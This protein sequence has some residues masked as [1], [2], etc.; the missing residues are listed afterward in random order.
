MSGPKA[1]KESAEQRAAR[2]AEEER[3]RIAQARAD[4]EEAAAGRQFLTKRTRAV[5]RLFGARRALAGVG[6]ANPI[7]APG[8]GTASSGGLGGGGGFGGGSGGYALGG[9]GGGFGWLSETRTVQN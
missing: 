1:P 8:G 7:A 2:L 5:M 3:I 4:A 9:G 6:G